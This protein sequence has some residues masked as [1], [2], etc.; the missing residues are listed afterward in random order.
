VNSVTRQV[1]GQ[2][3]LCTFMVDQ[4]CFGIDVRQVQEVLRYQPMTRVPLAPPVV[5]GLINLRGQIV[6]AIDLRRR[7]E[8]PEQADGG[9]PVNVVVRTADGIVSFLVDQLRDVV[10]V[11]DDAFEEPP[12]TLNELERELITGC[13]KTHDALLLV[14]DA[15]KAADVAGIVEQSL[16]QS[17]SID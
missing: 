3:Q 15:E 11:T 2:Q 8:L 13:Y 16:Q 4:L 5:R 7:L 14:L 6:M 1:N 9:A 17:N 12:S 10:V